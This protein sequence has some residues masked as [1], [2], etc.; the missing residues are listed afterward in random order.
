M[1][2]DASRL[3]WS[4]DEGSLLGTLAQSS[5]AVVAIV[6]G[7]LVS[8]LVQLSSEREGQR[9]QL[10]R[11]QDE[12]KHAT[13]AYGEAHEYRMANSRKD[14]YD[15]V[16]DDLIKADSSSLDRDALLVDHIPR[17]SSADEMA[18]RSRP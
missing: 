15:W 12:L 6:S 4:S 18:P 5:A 10:V 8:R 16:I 14:F 17:G 3:P 7:F 11:A 13:A 9:R 2:L 1:P